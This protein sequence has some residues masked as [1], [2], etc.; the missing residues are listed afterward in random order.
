MPILPQFRSKF[1][2]KGEKEIF[3]KA[4]DSKYFDSS[5]RYLIHSLRNQNTKNKIVGEIDFVYLDDQFVFF[6]ESKSGAVK[7]DSSKDEWWVLGGTKKGDPFAQVT[8]YLFYVRDTLLP[9]YFPDKFFN[10][11]LIFGYGVMFP[12]VEK[13]ISF[14]RHSKKS[15]NFKQETIEYDPE[16]IYTSSDHEAPNG[17]IKYIEHL[18]SYWRTHGRYSGKG[19]SFG[20]GHR[21]VQDIRQIFRKD[22]IFEVPISKILHRESFEIEKFT[23][24]QYSLLDNFGLIKNR[25]F[26][27]T[28]G[29]GTG[30][31][32][33][34]KE[35]L[36]RQTLMGKNCA[37]FCFNKNLSGEIRR[38]FG[39][40]KE[41]SLIDCFHVHGFIYDSLQAKN[42][43]PETDN[44]DFWSETLPLHFKLWH[45]GLGLKKYDFI[46]IDEAQDIFSENIVDAI[47]LNLEGGL[48]SGNWAMFLDYKYQKFYSG[49]DEDYYEL[50]L[51]TYP[52]TLHTLPLNCRNHPDIIE[53]ASSHSGL[54]SMPC[55]RTDVIFKTTINYYQESMELGDKVY[56]TLNDWTAKNI[57]PE[58]ITILCTENQ[59][60]EQ[61]KDVLGSKCALVSEK[62]HKQE[63]CFCLST[64]HSY[65]G[66]ENNFILIVGIN[67]FDRSRKDLMSLFF[68]GYT[69]AQMGLSIL[70]NEDVKK[71]LTQNILK[72]IKIDV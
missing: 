5:K 62:Q 17:L 45:S 25:G 48:E 37:Y 49:F 9:H 2:N 35:L 26:V 23:K 3:Q 8:D 24:E 64:I 52:C 1:D 57:P 68:V 10:Q 41:T 29:P 13:K 50:F 69:R 55:R 54:E 44:D 43:L 12:D 53:V 51:N 63:D 40:N 34:A 67:S 42:L 38:F 30:K 31:T 59:F 15:K 20:V 7:Y 4:V 61:I 71:D 14:S 32:I 16:I 27:V 39:T 70:L 46:L 47:F 33:L 65:K 60:L 36:S 18:K 21:D 66:L 19:R 72:N 22:L 56:E 28:G 11:R 58:E 6:L